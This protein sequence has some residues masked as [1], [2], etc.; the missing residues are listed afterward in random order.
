MTETIR[1]LTMPKWGLSMKEGKVV[2]WLVEEGAEISP[3]DEVADV[4]TDK[5]MAAVE[6]HEGG[7]LRRR[8]AG[9]GEVLP[10]GSLLAVLADTGASDSEIDAFV[11][12]FQASFLPPEEVGEETAGALTL[13]VS[14]RAIRYLKR[15][16]EGVPVILIHGFGGDLNNWLF[17]H[18]RIAAKHVVYALDLP[19]HG[20][21][22]KDVGDGTLD[23]LADVLLG[24]LEALEIAKVHLVGHSMG[25][26][27][28]LTFALAH[29]KRTASL[30]LI[31]S[32]SLGSEIDGAYIQ[33][34]IAAQRRKDMKPQLE[35]LF[36]DPSLVTRPLVEDVLKF[37]RI[38]GVQAALSTIANQSF[39]GGAQSVLLRDRLG[40]LSLPV[41]VV[42]GEKDQIIPSSHAQ[43][44]PR[45]V[46]AEIIP[47][48][49]HMVQME[50]P[51]EVNR[52]IHTVID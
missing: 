36:R 34:F 27:I 3:G 8:V 35:K 42:W 1:P 32:T 43:G 47:D 39:P 52:L 41:L 7:V 13:D 12:D 21:S 24:F 49:G 14:G 19:G 50:V 4:E 33:G 51:A 28:A 29:P 40:D 6:A 22:T 10:V 23:T 31:G 48:A 18:E 46:R 9:E 44:L 25:G 38:D 15:G 5:I 17:N 20:G 16:E 26:A 37:K 45:N 11:A 30:T 2:A